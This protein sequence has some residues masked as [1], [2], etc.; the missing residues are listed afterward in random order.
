[1]LAGRWPGFALGVP[2][3]ISVHTMARTCEQVRVAL[4]RG[5]MRMARN[6]RRHSASGSGASGAARRGPAVTKVAA[7][8]STVLVLVVVAGS[9]FGYVKYREIWD[10][11]HHDVVSGL[12][13]RPPKY[14]N[15]LNILVFGSDSRAGLTRQQQ[16][17]LHV[18]E[19]GCGCSDTIMVVHL[20]PGRHRAVVLNIPRD[21][22]VQQ[23]ACAAGPGYAGQPADP[24]GLVQIN[25]TLSRGGPS[26]LYKTV[27]QTTGIHIDHF[28][29]VEFTGVVKVVDDV[30][31][32][33]VCVPQN[34]SDPNSGLSISAGEHHINGLTFLEFWRARYSLADGTDLKRIDR[35]D[36]LLAQMFRGIISSGLLSSPTRLLPVVDDAARAIYATDAGLTQTDLLHVAESFRGL[37]SSNVQFIEAVSQPYPPAPAQVELVQPADGQLFAA[38]AHD[39]ALPKDDHAASGPTVPPA[40]VKVTVMNGTTVPNLAGD[41]GE[42]LAARGFQLEGTGDAAASSGSVIEYPSAAEL[43]AARTLAAQVTGATL[44]QDPAVSAGTVQLILGASFSSLAPQPGQPGTSPSTSPSGSPSLGSL[45]KTYG[46]ITGNANCKTDAGAFAP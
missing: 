14:N 13:N 4:M 6:G 15:A 22:M 32:V 29:Q 31:G 5:L 12:G 8:A 37:S 35:D 45:A 9:L 42:T 3:L 40:E 41:T 2:A 16:L 19:G 27:E 21:T 34:I 46:G 28:I 7:W 10:G 43:P 30:G 20:S 17:A 26:C 1:M 24:E 11:I 33:N 23:Y 25:Q 36:L 38:I 39:V 44:R 18:G